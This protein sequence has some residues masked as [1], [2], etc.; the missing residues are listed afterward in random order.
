MWVRIDRPDVEQML[1]GAG[2]PMALPVGNR[3]RKCAEPPVRVTATCGPVRV[4]RNRR[5][6]R[7]VAVGVV[8]I[9]AHHRTMRFD[10][11]R[12]TA[13]HRESTLGGNYS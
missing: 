5:M 13:N 4:V 12:H 2:K 9:V 3:Q 6:A 8:G 1:V 11:R 10:P 7:R